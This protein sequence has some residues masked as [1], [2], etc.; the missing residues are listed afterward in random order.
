MNQNTTLAPISRK[1]NEAL[2]HE[3]LLR[4]TDKSDLATTADV[5]LLIISKHVIGKIDVVAT[6]HCWL[7]RCFSSIERSGQFFPSIFIFIFVSKVFPY[8]III[9]MMRPPNGK[10]RFDSKKKPK[11]SHCLE[12]KRFWT[13]SQL[14]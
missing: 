1:L 7:V 8:C 14:P 2:K 13:T 4:L 12:Q 5:S 10:P 9:C 6:R 11:K 3:G